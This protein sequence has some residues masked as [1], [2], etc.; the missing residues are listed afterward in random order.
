MQCKNMAQNTSI[1]SIEVVIKEFVSL[2][3]ANVQEAHEN[4]EK[5]VAVTESAIWRPL[6]LRRAFS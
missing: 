5:A 1:A 6:K 4:A 2:A 3:D